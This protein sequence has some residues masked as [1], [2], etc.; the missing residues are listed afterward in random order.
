MGA[1]GT[2]VILGSALGVFKGVE[3]MGAG[4][5]MEDAGAVGAGEAGA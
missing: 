5:L 4:L 3:A 1:R 2:I